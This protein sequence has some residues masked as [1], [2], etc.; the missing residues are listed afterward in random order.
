[1]SS[2]C[3]RRGGRAALVV[4]ALVV[5]SVPTAC[6]TLQ[7][8]LELRRPEIRLTNLELLESG[9]FEQRFR[10]TLRVAN[11]NDFE[12]PIDG[13]R[14]DLAVDDSPLLKGLTNESVSVPRLG[15]ASVEID[16]YTSTF[17]VVRQL[18]SLTSR[19]EAFDYALSGTAF[20]TGFGVREIPFR[21]KG[22]LELAP[23]GG[24]HF[25]APAPEVRSAAPAGKGL[26]GRP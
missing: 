13:L 7:T 17:D 2:V 15:E 1:M 8:A 10:L 12:L 19:R 6:S 4:L 5:A 26:N 25:V 23:G 18:F 3:V 9:L 24:T 11:P 14:F 16:A 22:T 21:K 20:V